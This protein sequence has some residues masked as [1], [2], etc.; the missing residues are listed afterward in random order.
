VVAGAEKY[1]PAAHEADCGWHEVA[2]AVAKVEGV[3][4]AEKE[5]A[6]QAAQ[7]RSAVADDA[8]AYRNPAAH[9]GDCAAQPA[10]SAAPKVEFELAAAKVPAAHGEQTR[11]AVAEAAAV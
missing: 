7:R 10:A 2:T 1:D 8:A 11:S 9:V 3:A 4:E 5:P 6:G